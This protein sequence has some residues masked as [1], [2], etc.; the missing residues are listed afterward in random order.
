MKIP[1]TAEYVKA[2]EAIRPKIHD[3]QLKM[4]QAHYGARKREMT[5]TELAAAAGYET[6]S[7][8]NAHYGRLARLVHQ[9]L[10]I[11][12]PDFWTETLGDMRKIKGRGWVWTMRHEVAKALEQLKM[13]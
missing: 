7:P 13:V 11:G 10:G 9:E 12:V 6:Y 5:T 8:A 1:P 2:F 4:L 3:G